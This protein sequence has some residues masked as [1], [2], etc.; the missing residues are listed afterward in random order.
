MSDQISDQIS[1][2]ETEFITWSA[3]LAELGMPP[4]LRELSERQMRYGICSESACQWPIAGWCVAC[5]AK[6]CLDHLHEHRNLHARERSNDPLTQERLKETW[7]DLQ[8]QP[9]E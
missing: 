8:Q 1:E 7:S 6:L 9:Y 4:A 3:F 2:G 5:R